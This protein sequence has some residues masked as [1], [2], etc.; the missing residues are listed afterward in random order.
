MRFLYC[1]VGVTLAIFSAGCDWSSG[2]GDQVTAHGLIVT[3]GG[4]VPGA[5]A[6]IPGA[7]LRFVGSGGSATVRAD[8]RGR[9]S[10]DV[11]PGSY[12]VQV[13]G[14]G[15]TANGVF[16]PTIP[17]TILVPAGGFEKPFRLVVS[18]K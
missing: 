4:P 2:K 12:R 14:H 8:E 16:L 5:A 17:N 11:H 9:F 6:P 10:F 13:T 7:E 18:I 1:A 15:P 3:V